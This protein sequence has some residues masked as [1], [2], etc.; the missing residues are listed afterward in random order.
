MPGYWKLGCSWSECNS[1]RDIVMGDEVFITVNSFVNFDVPS[2]SVVIGNPGI[3]K[4]MENATKDYV[5]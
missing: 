1:S 2:N 3:I 4:H 5:D